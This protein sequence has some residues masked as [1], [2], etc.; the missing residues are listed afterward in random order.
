[1]AFKTHKYGFRVWGVLYV[2]HECCCGHS[3]D[4][5][6]SGCRSVDAEL[7]GG[8]LFFLKYIWALLVSICHWIAPTMPSG[9]SVVQVSGAQDPMWTPKS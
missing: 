4:S 6:F 7:A 3:Q 1:M 9:L 5:G 2:Y 8:Y